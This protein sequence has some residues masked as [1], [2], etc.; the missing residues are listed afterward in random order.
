MRRAIEVLTR[1]T[2]AR[3][4]GWYTGRLSP[5]TRRAGGRGGRLPL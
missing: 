1:V 4:L 2:G 5:N 3:P